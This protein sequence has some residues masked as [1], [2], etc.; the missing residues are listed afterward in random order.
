MKAFA[1]ILSFYI[2]VLTAIPCIDVPKDN[3]LRKVEL[4]KAISDKQDKDSDHCS[5]F[6]TCLCCAS[7]IIY[8]VYAFQFDNLSLIQKHYSEYKSD[9][10][11]NNY[12]TIWQPPKLS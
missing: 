4:S 12:S 9:F 10:I 5:P 6:C 7:S 1:Y 2:L 11:S 8:Q 3:T